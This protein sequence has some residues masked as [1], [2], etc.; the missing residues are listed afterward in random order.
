MSKGALA[1]GLVHSG[2]RFDDGD[3]T[4]TSKQG[5]VR[6]ISSTEERKGLEQRRQRVMAR[7][8]AGARA[9]SFLEGC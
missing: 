9:F 2:R 6:P 8:G 5:S 4:S 1:G 7:A 3:E